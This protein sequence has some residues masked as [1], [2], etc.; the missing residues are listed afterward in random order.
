[1]P[2][3][4][5]TH[6]TNLV[7]GE[8][9]RSTVAGPGGLRPATVSLHYAHVSRRAPSVDGTA[10]SLSIDPAETV[11]GDQAPS[12]LDNAIIGGRPNA[13][14]ASNI[15]T[16]PTPK[17][18]RMPWP[19]STATTPGDVIP[20]TELG[21]SY[22]HPDDLARVRGLHALSSA[23]F[24]RRHRI[25]TTTGNQRSVVVV[26]DAVT[27]FD[28]TVVATRGFYIDISDRVAIDVEHA[29][30][31]KIDTILARREVID[32][33]KGMLM[34][35]YRIDADAAFGVLRWRSQ[36]LNVKLITI[37]LQLLADLPRILDATPSTTT[38]VDHYLMK[39]DSNA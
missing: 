15:A 7:A 33:A 20:T 27:D 22:K 17:C 37:A 10:D 24:S 14:D 34:A 19:A 1:M 2:V 4:I 28:G 12:R 23:P 3:H 9:R 5:A 13:S 21:L 11:S 16:T 18:G 6:D 8:A 29:V 38:P 31:D 39:H 30:D 25:I 32:Q 26:G 35:I 36:E